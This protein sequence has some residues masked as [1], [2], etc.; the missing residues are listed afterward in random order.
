[1]FYKNHTDLLFERLENDLEDAYDSTD[2]T[3]DALW[4]VN[5]GSNNL[6]QYL[7]MIGD[8][9]DLWQRKESI[10]MVGASKALHFINP[11]LFVPWD[12]SIMEYYHRETSH[13]NHEL[14]GKE[15][16]MEFMKSCNYI[17]LAVLSRASID[18]LYKR[19]PAYVSRRE[20]R[21]LPKMIDECNYCWITRNERW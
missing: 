11:K 14:G 21:T 12:S 9:Y 6:D 17:A 16:Y 18:E 7:D 5:L 3:L 10:R 1:M 19:H 8:V 4:N 2:Q 20:I 13:W 15:C